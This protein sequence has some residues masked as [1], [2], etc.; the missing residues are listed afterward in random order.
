MWELDCK[1]AEHER[2]DAFK[3]WCW[4]DSWES[5]GQQGDQTI[6]PKGNQS[7]I[8]FGRTDAE[9]EAVILWPPNV[10]SRFIEK[11]LMLDK[12]EGRRRGLQMIR[13]LDGI[14]DSMDMSLRKFWETVKNRE[15][16]VL[17]SMRLQ[18]V[19]QDLVTK[20]QQSQE[21]VRDSDSMVIWYF[22]STT[23]LGILTAAMRNCI[24]FTL[25]ASCQFPWYFAFL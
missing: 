7:W 5:L 15:P 16:G 17:Q 2:I 22:S 21:W 4:E 12:F 6:N 11:T 10:K 8:F 19:R 25:K 9:A 1:K 13:W 14:T 18:R 20:Q 3:L 23:I 24:L